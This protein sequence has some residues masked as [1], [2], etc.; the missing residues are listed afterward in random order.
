MSYKILKIDPTLAPFEKD[1]NLRMEYYKQKKKALLG[2]KGK[3]IDWANGHNYFGFHRTENGWV[4]RE[5]APAAERM[6]LTGDF[7]DWNVTSHPMTRLN[8]G[9][10]E[11]Y[12]S[13]Q[14]TLKPGQKVQA[15]V[16]SNDRE[17]RRIP[18][19]ATRVVQD[20]ATYLWCAELEE[21][22][23]SFPWTDEDFKPEKSPLIYECHIGM[24]GEDYKVSSYREFQDNVLPRIK[25]LGYNTIQIMAIME[26]PYYGSFG[27]QVSNFFAASSR[28]GTSQE[29][30]ELINTAH[31]MGIAVLLDVVHSHAVNN[32]NEGIN[33][34]DGTTYQFF[35]EGE[36]GNHSAW[37]TKLFNY[38]KHEVL[39]F[40][41]SNLKYW[42]EEFHFD[43]FRF[44]GVTSM[45]YHDHGL[46]SAF[47]DYSMYFSPNTDTDAVTYL[48][49]A[50]ELIHSLNTHAITIAEDMSGMPGMC[51]PI[52]DGGIGFD[53]RLSMGVPDLWIKTLKESTDEAWDM[54]KLW[55]ELTGRRPQEKTIG[56]AESHDQALVGDKTLMFRLCDAEMYTSMSKDTP[57]I[58]IDR[59]IALH[60]MIRLVTSSLAGEGYLNF[61]G[62]EFGHP[63]WI[64][65]PREGN[66]WS[67]HYCR[68]QWSLADNDLL[69]YGSLQA[70]DEAMISLLKK[71]H[72]LSKQAYSLWTG[73]QEKTLIY[74]KGNVVFAFNFHPTQ[75][76]DGYFIPVLEEGT[77][78]VILSTDDEQFGGPNRIDTEYRY[79]TKKINGQLGFKCYLPSRS[80]LVLKKVSRKRKT[81]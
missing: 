31:S 47:T 74:G 4:Y 63:E 80:A 46:G 21:P 62:N 22:T 72:L 48:Q 23:V 73:Q 37:G 24:S 76:F 12:I 32:T 18:L 1:I 34:F 28:Y 69:R 58:V 43:G 38:G 65:F 42:M 10:F 81:S 57:S 35:H 64:D 61:M 79:Q 17:L 50:N 2:T 44:D 45:L 75:S 52:R 33:E 6:F 67:Y 26:H 70:F 13:G 14:D 11:I 19:Y 71:E 60:K 7:N 20:P 3:L 68:R 55:Y 9:I 49:L 40:L 29:L 36:K 8:N 77:Y 59:G 66:N 54:F 27:Y 25:S 30:R 56:Y 16:I 51:I 5:W 53:Y 78:A 15:I 41:L 39:H